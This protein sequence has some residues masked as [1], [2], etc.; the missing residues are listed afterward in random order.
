MSVSR[1]LKRM[2]E[3]V[4]DKLKVLQLLPDDAEYVLDVGCAAGAV[5]AHMANLRQGIHFHGIDVE[6]PFVG[7]AQ[8]HNSVGNLSFSHN[9][10]SDLH[11]YDTKYDAITF[12]SVLHEFYSY[13]KGLTSVVKALCDAHELLKPGGRIIIR[14]ML[15][16][17]NDTNLMES[18][19]IF[20]KLSK[21]TNVNDCL[22]EYQQR[23]GDISHSIN[24]IN[25]F[26]LHLLYRDNWEHELRED[27]MFWT[28]DDY[29]KFLHHVLGLEYVHS[30]SYLLD[31]TKE[32]WRKE[33]WMNNIQMDNLYSTGLV[34]FEK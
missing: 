18:M 7:M 30:E 33:L 20:D 13:G 28:V 2:D 27:Y 19:D 31:Y 12:M 15:R 29:N 24:R 1:Y 34:A 25:D 5:T 32:R 22:W 10:L 8:N 17:K 21:L 23:Y 11:Q 6:L 26:M 9:W 3:S 4:D 16:P 14:D